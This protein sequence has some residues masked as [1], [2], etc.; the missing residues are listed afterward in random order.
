[1]C[2]DGLFYIYY[3][4]TVLLQSKCINHDKDEDH[5][6]GYTSPFF[7]TSA[8]NTSTKGIANGKDLY[9]INKTWLYFMNHVRYFNNHIKI[10]ILYFNNHE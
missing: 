1:M 4:Y 6:K 5:D 3:M 8:T 10:I 7:W 9:V 2:H